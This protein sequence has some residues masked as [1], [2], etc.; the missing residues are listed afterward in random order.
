MIKYL[1]YIVFTL[2][3]AAVTF[4]GMGPVLFADGPTSERVITFVIVVIIYVVLIKLFGYWEK[5]FR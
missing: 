5:R 4:F 3:I 2:L 1:G